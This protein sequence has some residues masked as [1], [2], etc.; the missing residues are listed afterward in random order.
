MANNIT[1]PSLYVYKQDRRT[2]YG[3]VPIT[4]EFT[5]DVRF[6]ACSEISFTTPDTYYDINKEEW[7]ENSSYDSLERGRLLFVTDD[8]S[9]FKF[10]VRAIGDGSF[11]KYKSSSSQYRRGAE[12][13]LNQNPLLDN[14]QV[15]SETELFDIGTG[16]GYS[17]KHFAYIDDSPQGELGCERDMSFCH[18]GS[19]AATYNPMLSLNIYIPAE[20]TDVISIY[21]G[22]T[23]L[24]G[25]NDKPTYQWRVAAYTREDTASYVGMW[26]APSSTGSQRINVAEKLP[27]GGYLRFW[28]ECSTGTGGSSSYTYNASGTS[29]CNWSYP[30]QGF[31]KLYSGERRCTSVSNSDR[32]GYVYPKLHWYQI[33]SVDEEDDGICR[34]KTVTAYSYEYSLQTSTFSLSAATLPF[35]IPE[36]ITN[37]VNSNPWVRDYYEAGSRFYSPQRMQRGVLNQILDYL[38]NWSIKYVSEELMA[39]Y[40]SLDDVDDISVYSYLMDTLQS[41]YNCFIVFDSDDMTISAYSLNDINNI[42]SPLYLSWDNAIKHFEK[43]NMDASYFTAL[44]VHAGD[45]MYGVGLV[46]PTGNA[47][48]YNDPR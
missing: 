31:A 47:M 46:N 27:D 8:T 5:S 7:V 33:I 25:S 16:G 41:V 9:Y 34:K 36:A 32:S 4:S 21:S 24:G 28:Y 14:F 15:Q 45:N 48:I 38:P 11:Y 43:K 44:R 2:C 10:P 30:V 37:L 1:P 29:Y 12:L 35:F 17:F 3:C 39:T 13:A 42:Q 40:R 26:K 20:S 23:N 18:W 19:G 6:N 22:H